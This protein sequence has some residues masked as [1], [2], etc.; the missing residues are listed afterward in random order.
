MVQV[1]GNVPDVAVNA[2]VPV[3][4]PLESVR[5]VLLLVPSHLMVPTF[6]PWIILPVTMEKGE[7]LPVSV[8]PPPKKV[9]LLGL[10]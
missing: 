1:A 5:A 3:N 4:L 6:E 8:I 7:P 10:A 2:Q 9:L